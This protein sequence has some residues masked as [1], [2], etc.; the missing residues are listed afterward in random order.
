VY[1]LDAPLNISF[2]MGPH[3]I[4]DIGKAFLHHL[5]AG[6]PAKP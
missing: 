1:I 4:N 2:G 3:Y 6:G 5:K